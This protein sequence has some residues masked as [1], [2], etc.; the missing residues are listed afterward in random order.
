VTEATHNDPDDRRS[1][2]L[3][4]LADALVELLLA[5]AT[6]PRSRAEERDGGAATSP[7]GTEARE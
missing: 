6:S 4:V 1:A 2:M 5:P 7:K 3:E